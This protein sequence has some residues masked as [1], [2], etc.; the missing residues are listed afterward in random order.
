M[1]ST[2]STIALLFTAAAQAQTAPSGGASAKRAFDEIV[3][4]SQRREQTLESVPIAVDVMDA[5]SLK[6]AKVTSV[7]DI[8]FISPS[9]T[10]TGD[11][12]GSNI[13]FAIR[14]LGSFAPQGNIEQA[15][16]VMLNGI[17]LSRAAEFTAELDDIERVEIL[18]GP[19]GSL[20]G[21]NTTGGVVNIVHARPKFEFEGRTAATV[22]NDDEISVR[23]M[24]NTPLSDRVAGR[25]NFTYKDRDGHIKNL[26]PGGKDL[27]FEKTILGDAKFLFEVTDDIELLVGGTYRDNQ[28]NNLRNPTAVETDPRGLARLS[29][30][31]F[32]DPELGQA[33][34]DDIL[35]ANTDQD[36]MMNQ[37][38]W[39]VF[40]DLK[41]DINS[42][43]SLNIL[44]SFVDFKQDGGSAGSQLD[45]DSGP[46]SITN[47]LGAAEAGIGVGVNPTYTNTVFNTDGGP[48]EVGDN[49]QLRA[50]N[51]ATAEVRLTGTGEHLDWTTGFFF[52]RHHEE[53]TF[54]TPFFRNGSLNS[55]GRFSDVEQENYA[56]FADATWHVTSSLDVF[57]GFRGIQQKARVDFRRKAFNVP[58]QDLIISESADGNTIVE[59]PDTIDRTPTVDI[60][61]AN[62]S[63]TGWAGR[64][65]A[66]WNL[67]EAFN[68]KSGNDVSIYVNASRGYTGFG[69]NTGNGTVL[70]SLFLL[71]STSRSFE[72]GTKGF[73]FDR[74]VNFNIALFDMHV[75]DFQANVIPGAGELF[76]FSPGDFNSQGIEVDVVWLVPEVPLTLDGS[77]T[78]LNT[79]LANIAPQPCYPGQTLAQGCFIDPA[80]NQPRQDL[81][82]LPGFNAPDVAFNMTGTYD[83]A[84]SNWFNVPF[85]TSLRVSYT[86]QDDV[87]FNFSNDPLG[88]FEKSYGLLDLNLSFVD[89]AGKYRVDFFG[90][91]I[92]NQRFVSNRQSQSGTAGRG[93][94]T[95]SRAAQSYW[96]LELTLNY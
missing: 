31:G 65:G 75:S 27:G 17:A 36:V 79:A 63:P 24:I 46:S 42:N 90:K 51:Y 74:S 69:T 78:I 49:K 57:A 5:N 64:A 77:I 72:V 76:A 91:N 45:I 50:W 47:T 37:E 38:G 48:G 8:A 55:A 41:W 12:F 13:N 96:G 73:L 32:G 94:A 21:A 14:G 22:T 62:I 16:G 93:V 54:A 60:Q 58:F 2:V 20:F 66:S 82:G 10:F 83:F 6:A 86:W 44:T 80:S 53:F 25:F 23:Q 61:N 40:G 7:Q 15:V 92:T 89:V 59:I 26:F 67:T 39:Q 95:V 30:L 29:A 87:L 68:M 4:T 34:V 33:I 35:L 9:M 84:T 70:D 1:V 71:P 19:Q 85:D 88:S 81:N 52:R 3:V 11:V 18:K 56:L 43:I 28:T